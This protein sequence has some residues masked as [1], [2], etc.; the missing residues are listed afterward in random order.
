MVSAR[1]RIASASVIGSAHVAAGLP[2][3]DRH[4]SM[5]LPT[6]S[7]DILLAA[8]A[9]GAGS[10]AYAEAGAA[11]AVETILSLAEEHLAADPE[12]IALTD[13]LAREWISNVASTLVLTAEEA[14]VALE[15]YASTLLAAFV[16]NDWCA[17]LQVGD[18]AIVASTPEGGWSLISWPQHG[19]FANS[20]TFLTS[21]GAAA[22]AFFEMRHVRIDDLTMFSD[23]LENLVL[24]K[25]MRRAHGPFFDMKI[26]PVRR[27]GAAG[28]D[29]RLSAE[30]HAYLTSPRVCVRT[31]DDKTLILASRA[32][33]PVSGETAR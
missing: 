15:E 2:C 8:V 6:E 19:E 1:W 23:G 29:P 20:T 22:R 14:G 5:L 26:A 16:G 10:A 32:A 25:A 12:G 13:G 33:I 24:D 31:D 3:Q 18:G 28:T 30:L 11:I 17:F 21:K 9:D 7:G 27:S 4:A